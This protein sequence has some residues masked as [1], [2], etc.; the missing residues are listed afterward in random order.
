MVP[1]AIAATWCS[2]M[3]MASPGAMRSAWEQAGSPKI[4]YL[5]PHA[6]STPSGDI[7]ELDAIRSVFANNLPA[8]SAIRADR[9]LHRRDKRPGGCFLPTDD[10]RWV[11]RGICQPGKPDPGYEDFPRGKPPSVGSIPHC[12]PASDRRHQRRADFSPYVNRQRR[13]M[14]TAYAEQPNHKGEIMRRIASA[15]AVVA[16]MLLA[17]CAGTVKNMKEVA[18]EGTA[19][20][21]RPDGGYGDLHA[22][23]WNGLCHPIERLRNQERISSWSALSRPRPRVAHRVPAGNHLYMVVG[24]SADL[25]QQTSPRTRPTTPTSRH[26]WNVEG[27][28]R[29]RA[30]ASE[31]ARQRRIWAATTTNAIGNPP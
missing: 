8:I 16:A 12:R 21:P 14:Q 17:G 22:P 10:A 4:D 27:T 15:I 29:P 13:M 23:V 11:C 2:R 30:E 6:T 9:A 31:R 19:V 26:A 1:S 24:E 3:L 5:S 18:D 25:R 28:L 20:K 7:A